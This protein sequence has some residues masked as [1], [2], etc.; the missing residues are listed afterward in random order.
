MNRLDFVKTGLS[1]LVSVGAGII[2]G[3]AIKHT[4]PTNMKFL[5]K[6]CIGAASVVLTS[7]SG[8]IAGK[9]TE[10]KFD[11]AVKSIQDLIRCESRVV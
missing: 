6:L 7:V 4:T 2:V 10:E 1:M 5:I 9:Y 3:N 8:D 11:D